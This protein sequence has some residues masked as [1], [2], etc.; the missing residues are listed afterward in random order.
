[1]VKKGALVLGLSLMVFSGSSAAQGL[2]SLVSPGA[3]SRA[4]QNVEG[5][6]GCDRCHTPGQG[7]DDGKCLACHRQIAARIRDRR[8]FH[9]TRG[10]QCATCHP[11]HRGEEASLLPWD[12][13]HFDHSETGYPLT[14]Y[15]AQ[16]GR[17]ES[18]HSPER[19]VKRV[20][21]RS[22]LLKDRTCVRDDRALSERV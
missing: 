9:R 18:C 7:V 16:V 21:G 2:E 20:S 4:H 10:E 8:G 13:A 12:P 3:L 11:E 1:M 22:F 5:L 17:C 14:G 6:D 19:S 15:H